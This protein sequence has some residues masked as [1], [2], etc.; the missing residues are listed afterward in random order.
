MQP[1]SISGLTT[2]SRDEIEKPDTGD[3]DLWLWTL[4]ISQ[5][6]RQTS[7]CLMNTL[8][9]AIEAR[10]GRTARVRAIQEHGVSCIIG[11]GKTIVLVGLNVDTLQP[12]IGKL[13][14]RRLN[15]PHTGKWQQPRRSGEIRQ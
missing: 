15:R 5:L 13:I 2:L 11:N 7:N 8:D 12:H 10:A 1:D 3:R 9:C 14:H 6:Q 4:F